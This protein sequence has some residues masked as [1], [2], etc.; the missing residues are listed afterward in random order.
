MLAHVLSDGGGGGDT[1]RE[2]HTVDGRERKQQTE[3]TV[4]RITTTRIQ[5]K[6]TSG[7]CPPTHTGPLKCVSAESPNSVD[8]VFAASERETD[9]DG[10]G[11]SATETAKA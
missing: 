9:S 8:C 7:Q 6:V 4:E 11:D 5:L 2:L 10:D 3:S 1:W